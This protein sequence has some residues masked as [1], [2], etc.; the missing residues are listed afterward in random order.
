MNDTGM[1]HMGMN[2]RTLLRLGVGAAALTVLGGT[3]ADY[4]VSRHPAPVPLDRRRLLVLELAGG[5][6]GLSMVVPRN[7]SRYHDLRKRT[8]VDPASTHRLNNELGLHPALAKTARDGVSVVAGI[9]VARPDLSHFEMLQR[10][11]TGD[12]DGKLRPETGFLGRLCDAIGDRDAPAVGVSLGM[13][14]TQTLACRAVTTLSLDSGTDGRFPMLDD[15]GM[16]DAWMAAQRAMAHPDRGDSAL[17]AH[18]RSANAVA[19]RFSDVA[20]GLPAAADGYPAN[21]LGAQL[22]LAARLL[23]DD[24]LGLRVVHVPVGADFD[25]HT[26]HLNRYRR[27]MTDLDMCLWRFRADLAH[28]GIADNVLIACF[29]EF[30]RR[31]PDNDSSGLDHGAASAALLL[32]PTHRGVFGEQPSLADLDA[33]DNLKPTVQMTEFYATLAEG[34]FGVP[35]SEILPGAPKPIPGILR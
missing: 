35:A 33:D 1:N 15:D 14:S 21:D 19:L 24:N 20:A 34:W 2:R 29:S 6:D 28:R 16:V 32:G 26:D 7:D 13:G 8:A 31:V 12:P 17:M 5:N 27:L 10:W 30:G 11:W 18:T 3:G 22:R 23:A 4:A 9:G 25:T